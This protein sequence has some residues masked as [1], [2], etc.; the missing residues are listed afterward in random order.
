M[1]DAS[2]LLISPP[3]FETRQLTSDVGLGFLASALRENLFRVD[4]IDIKRDLISREELAN[5]V[6]SGGYLMAGIK[7]FSSFV[8]E[9]NEVINAVKEA[10]P[11]IKIVIGGPHASY[12][13]QDALR[14]CPKA[15]VGVIGEG[16]KV[17]V[18]LA[19]RFE[20]SQSIDDVEAICYRDGDTIR[21][22]ASSL[23][24]KPCWYCLIWRGARYRG[25]HQPVPSICF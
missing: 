14:S 19:R 11:N 22:N 16:E 8:R 6:R 18:D 2:I 9:A 3:I 25:R 17:V 10:D 5:R 12:A 20:N 21:K 7:V 1:P 24:Y 4:F 23:W 13:K 15:D